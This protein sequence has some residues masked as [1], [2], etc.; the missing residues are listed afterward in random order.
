M[1]TCIDNDNDFSRPRY[2]DHTYREYSTYIERGGKIDKHKKSDRN[3][4]ALLHIMLSDEQYSHVIS[5]MPHGRAW[6]IIDKELL[7]EEAA[8]KFFGQSKYAS[9]AR[10]LSGWGFKRLHKAGP[11]FGCYYHE[12]FLRGHPRLTVLMRRLSPGEG[13]GTPNIYAEPDFYLIAKNYPLEK[14]ATIS[15]KEENDASNYEEEV[16]SHAEKQAV[17]NMESVSAHHWDPYDQR[18]TAYPT[19]EATTVD[20]YAYRTPFSK[21]SGQ[22]PS[23]ANVPLDR[24]D[25]TKA[26]EEKDHEAMKYDPCS[27][28]RGD[29]SM[30]QAHHEAI[31][32]QYYGYGSQAAAGSGYYYPKPSHSCLRDAHDYWF[33]NPYYN[34]HSA[35]AHGVVHEHAHKPQGQGASIAQPHYPAQG[36]HHDYNSLFP[37]PDFTPLKSIFNEDE[38]DLGYKPLA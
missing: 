6:K 10:Q 36:D 7:M 5:W 17:G 12:C 15:S 4:P 19:R 27:L 26:E 16:V 14:S 33:G 28:P 38:E 25:D 9:F 8:P 11:D 32:N 20:R 18:D 13:R 35:Q 21:C 31:M 22:S 34:N 3:F 24:G 30:H 29:Y 2:T 1:S 23:F 37:P